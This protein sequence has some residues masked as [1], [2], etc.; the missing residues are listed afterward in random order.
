MVKFCEYC[1]AKNEGQSSFCGD[2]GK[3]LRKSARPVQPTEVPTPSPA[4]PMRQVSLSQ[5]P[6][7]KKGGAGAVIAVL[8][9]LVVLAGAALAV[10]FVWKPFDKNREPST[11]NLID[12]QEVFKKVENDYMALLPEKPAPIQTGAPLPTAAPVEFTPAPV[13]SGSYS[14]DYLL[15]TMDLGRGWTADESS[16]LSDNMVTFSKDEYSILSVIWVADTTTYDFASDYESYTEDFAAG[17]GGTSATV[18]EQGWA[19]T[20]QNYDTFY[21]YYTTFIDSD[22]HL[23]N[24]GF[25]IDDGYGG[26][27]LLNYSQS[28][29][30]ATQEDLDEAINMVDSFTLM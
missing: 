27:Y 13:Q 11:E 19:V 6:P 28:A 30:G 29:S 21:F 24:Y 20:E 12:P 3:E 18:T 14:S 25:V 26:C 5:K 10:I 17:S 15:F 22:Q 8:L 4:H 2:C 16:L 23:Y 1:G 7:K 9:A